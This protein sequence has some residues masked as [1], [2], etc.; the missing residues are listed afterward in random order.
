MPLGY[1]GNEAWRDMSEYVVHFTRDS[2]RSALENMLAIL[3]SQ[4]LVPGGAFGA[5]R[6]LDATGA[7]QESVCFSEIPLDRLDRLVERRG[8]KYGIGFRQDVLVAAGG[9]RVWYV[10]KDGDVASAVNRVI[11]LAMGPPFEPD[12]PIWHLTPLIDFPGEYGQTQY[13]FEWEREWRVPGG[14]DFATGDVAFLFVP[15]EQH[16]AARTFFANPETEHLGPA[17][18]CPILDPL[19]PDERIQE[20]LGGL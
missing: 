13:R 20:A 18:H 12:H 14:L 1:R 7:P 10:D 3:G 9:G 4:R 2:D 19:W 6:R 15:E 5:G 11:G 16:G 17:Y 8:T